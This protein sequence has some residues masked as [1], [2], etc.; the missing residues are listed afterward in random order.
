MMLLKP[1][2]HPYNWNIIRNIHDEDPSL[3][4]FTITLYYHVVFGI[5][6]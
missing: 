4:V 1:H 3:L 5:S 6:V 2:N